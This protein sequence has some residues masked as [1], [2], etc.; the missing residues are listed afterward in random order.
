[1]LAIIIIFHSIQ[2]IYI[3]PQYSPVIGYHVAGKLFV[4]PWLPM[5]PIFGNMDTT[6][7]PNPS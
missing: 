4:P 2:I 5:L 3:Y 7:A 1:M 6:L